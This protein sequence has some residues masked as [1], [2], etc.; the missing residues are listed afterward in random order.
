M[1]KCK[2]LMAGLPGRERGCNISGNSSS[3]RGG[4][5]GRGGCGAGRESS[6]KITGASSEVISPNKTEIKTTLFESTRRFYFDRGSLCFVI[7]AGFGKCLK[8]YCDEKI[9]G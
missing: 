9:K 6:S 4:A 8:R 1:Y 3:S 7:S 2:Y 5:P